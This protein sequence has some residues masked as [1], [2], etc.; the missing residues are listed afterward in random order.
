M[1]SQVGLLVILAYPQKKRKE[2]NGKSCSIMSIRV[3]LL[4]VIFMK[5]Q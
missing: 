5:V 4:Q 2:Q 3:C 1:T